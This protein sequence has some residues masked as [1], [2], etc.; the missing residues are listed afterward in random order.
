MLGVITIIFLLRTFEEITWLYLGDSNLTKFVIY[1]SCIIISFYLRYD[2]AAKIF[3]Y[4]GILASTT[5]LYWLYE[6]YQAP[7]IYWNMT[8]VAITLISRNLIFSRVS[9]TEHY[10][11]KIMRLEAKSIN[12]DWIIY[13]LYGL[14]LIL[15]IIVIL[16]YLI[17]HLFGASELVL[18]Y[19][20]SAYA[21]RAISTLSIWA[22]FNESYK[23]LAPKSL[24]A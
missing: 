3:L 10:L 22:I 12:L 2:W 16:E 9:I 11:S 17:R 21:I 8:L 14:S 19:Y 24:K 4:I 1:P 7:Q 13:R 20:S 23:Q 6:D 18:F 15:Q 5:E